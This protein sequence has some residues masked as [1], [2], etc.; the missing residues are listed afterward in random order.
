M[1]ILSDIAAKHSGTFPDHASDEW[2]EQFARWRT[3]VFTALQEEEG[4]KQ[5]PSL[6]VHTCLHAA[7]RWDKLRTFKANDIFDFFHASAALAYCQ[8][9]FTERSLCATITSKELGLDK[10]YNCHVVAKVEDAITYVRTLLPK[11]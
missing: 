1:E 10:F 2:N 11:T 8:A 5:L 4:C 9:F 6:H 7:F 3:V